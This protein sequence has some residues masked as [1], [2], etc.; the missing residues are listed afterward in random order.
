MGPRLERSCTAVP[1]CV[2]RRGETTRNVHLSG[3]ALSPMYPLHWQGPESGRGHAHDPASHRPCIGPRRR[4]GLTDPD[5]RAVYT[6]HT[7]TLPV[8][9]HAK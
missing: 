6:L 2:R 3:M 7:E 4:R 5:K 8:K 1:G 9:A